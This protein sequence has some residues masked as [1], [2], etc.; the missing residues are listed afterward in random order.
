MQA[1]MDPFFFFDVDVSFTGQKMHKYAPC[2]GI[3]TQPYSARL[4]GHEG[5]QPF[6]GM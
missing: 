3:N 1:K 4:Q 5:F 6:P 2:F